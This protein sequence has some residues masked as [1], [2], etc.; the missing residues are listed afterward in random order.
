MS[1]KNVHLPQRDTEAAWQCWR[2][3]MLLALAAKDVVASIPAEKQGEIFTVGIK[4]E[5]WI[6]IAINSA[7]QSCKS[8]GPRRYHKTLYLLCTEVPCFTG[9]CSWVGEP[10]ETGMEGEI[11]WEHPKSLIPPLLTEGKWKRGTDRT[12][13]WIT[14]GALGK[15]R[16]SI[17]CEDNLLLQ[18][19]GA[20][21]LGVE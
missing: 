1:G 3:K 19:A 6:A 8:V 10:S 11:F 9:W 14:S 12:W 21:V 18:K 7:T 2:G 17:A 5:E 20:A 16:Y 4:F 15:A 13:P